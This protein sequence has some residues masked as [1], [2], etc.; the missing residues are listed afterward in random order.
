M[1]TTLFF[2]QVWTKS[3]DLLFEL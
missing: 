1:R 3:I 2:S